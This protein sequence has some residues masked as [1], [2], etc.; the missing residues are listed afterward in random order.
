[1]A[2]T[3]EQQ[4]VKH[5]GIPKNAVPQITDFFE[6]KTLDKG[7]VLVNLGGRCQQMV[8]IKKG[9]ARMFS[10]VQDKEV[11]HWIAGEDYFITELASFM[12]DLPSRWQIE[13]ITEMEVYS[14]SK[15]N[16]NRL[17]E[18]VPEWDKIEKQFLVNCFVTM[19]NRISAHLS[20]SAEDRYQLFFEMNKSMFN[21]VPLQY[22]A[23]MLG[24]SSET[25]SRIRRKL[26]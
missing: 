25:L 14:I 19:E 20:L 21:Q 3:L 2:E 8:F 11:T 23:S 9:F 17:V 24:M 10:Y 16:Y 7:E 26:F 15:A 1:M 5:L 12:H 6:F 22:I 13:A 18:V 4:I